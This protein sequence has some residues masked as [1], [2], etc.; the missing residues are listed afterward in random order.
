MKT[1]VVILLSGM[2]CFVNVSYSQEYDPI[3]AE[4][5]TTTKTFEVNH[6]AFINNMTGIYSKGVDNSVIVFND[7][8]TYFISI[9]HG[10]NDIFGGLYL[11]NCTGYTVQENN[12]YNTDAYPYP[13]EIVSIGITVNDSEDNLNMI[14]RNTF[15]GLHMGILAQNRNR[16]TSNGTGLKLKC[17]KCTNNRGDFAVTA[18]TETANKGISIHQGAYIPGDKT[19]PAGNLF[20]HANNNNPYSDFNNT[21]SRQWIYYFHHYG[22]SLNPW[23]PVYYQ[24]ITPVAFIGYDDY[25]KVCP[26]LVGS[27]G[28]HIKSEPIVEDEEELIARISLMENLRDSTVNVL[29]LWIDAGNTPELNDLVEFSTPANHSI[30]MMN[31]WPIPLTCPIRC[32]LQVLKKKMYWS[33]P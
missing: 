19:A 32:C 26:P 17:N 21:L 20:S 14:Y 33:T 16:G 28:G 9:F 12:F 23:V 6:S 13:D 22:N 24:N 8:D 5:G 10:P 29:S 18:D 31:L 3:K 27:G 1:I 30:S 11:D 2:I 4:N 15:D 7:F 25:D